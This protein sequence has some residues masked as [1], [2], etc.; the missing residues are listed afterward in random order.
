M[1]GLGPLV[2]ALELIR[3][4]DFK[5]RVCSRLWGVFGVYLEVCGNNRVQVV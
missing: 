4:Q 5:L 2:A 3:L 1:A